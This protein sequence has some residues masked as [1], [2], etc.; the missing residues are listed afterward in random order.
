[1]QSCAIVRVR[2]LSGLKFWGHIVYNNV[3]QKM[4]SG[5]EV[6]SVRDTLELSVSWVIILL[7][8]QLV[9]Q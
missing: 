3:I 9:G 2:A 7:M 6:V 8:Y 5:L 1:M 4:E